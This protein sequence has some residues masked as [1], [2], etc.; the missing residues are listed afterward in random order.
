MHRPAPLQSESLLQLPANTARPAT[1]IITSTIIAIH[2]VIWYLLPAPG[3]QRF[4]IRTENRQAFPKA[5]PAP[6]DQHAGAG[7]RCT[8]GAVAEHALAGSTSWAAHG[9]ST[10]VPS[11]WSSN[12]PNV[13]NGQLL[14]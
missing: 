8:A 2:R 4:E 11:S 12:G 14:Q 6:C 7:A 9:A 3:R 10:T 5:Q 1:A 13:L